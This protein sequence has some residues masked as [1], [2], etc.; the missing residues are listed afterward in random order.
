MIDFIAEYAE[1]IEEAREREKKM[2]RYRPHR[3]RGDDAWGEAEN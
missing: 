1:A 2:K 3:K